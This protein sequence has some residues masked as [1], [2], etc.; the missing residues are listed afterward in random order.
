MSGKRRHRERGR[1]IAARHRQVQLE[2]LAQGVAV[3]PTALAPHTSSCQPVFVERGYYVDVPFECRSCGI[4]QTWTAA[5]QKWWYEVAKG[6][7]FTTA[8][9]CRP[10]RHR[11]RDVNGKPRGT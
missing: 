4:A 9:L 11:E 5:Q 3:D 6:S 2:A 10:C 7:V 1:Q 8:S